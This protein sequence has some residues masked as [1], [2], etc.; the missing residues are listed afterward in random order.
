MSS[1]KLK[2]T[3]LVQDFSMYSYEHDLPLEITFC[4]RV[5]LDLKMT[6]N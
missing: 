5:A 3:E 2:T 1:F 6:H 4:V